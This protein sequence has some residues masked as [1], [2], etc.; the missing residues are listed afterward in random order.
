[1]KKPEIVR[2]MKIGSREGLNSAVY[3]KK[4]VKKRVGIKSLHA[5][6]VAIQRMQEHV[7]TITM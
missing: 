2:Q 6:Q 5:I 1:M 7:Y 4:L 3:F